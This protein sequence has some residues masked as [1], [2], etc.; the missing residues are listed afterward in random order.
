[1]HTGEPLFNGHNEFDQMN[2]IVEVLGMPPAHMLE[3]GSKSRRYFDRY[4][5]GSWQLKRVKEGKKYKQPGTR[6]LRDLLGSDT[7]G[8]QSRRINEPGHL[9]ND[10]LKFEDIIVR[11]LHYDPKLRITPADS[12]QH[13]FFKRPSSETSSLAVNES[14]NTAT[15]A[16]HHHMLHIH[17]ANTGAAHNLTSLLNEHGSLLAAA[18]NS[19]NQNTNATTNNIV[20]DL[21]ALTQNV[22]NNSNAS[23]LGGNANFLNSS[24]SNYLDTNYFINQAILNNEQQG[25]SGGGAGSSSSNNN[26]N[27]QSKFNRII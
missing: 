17:S 27:L 5:D 11:M 20:N 26:S 1:M 2:K 3:Q 19:S 22:V 13:S 25:G 9:L 16:A 21:I 14:G 8:P 15:A 23:Q 7:G 24:N 6:R 10:Y 4:P 12:L 18:A